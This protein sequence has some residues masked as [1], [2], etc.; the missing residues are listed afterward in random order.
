MSKRQ[1]NEEEQEQLQNQRNKRKVKQ[2]AHKHK[3]TFWTSLFG[4]KK[5][6]RLKSNSQGFSR[7]EDL[8][9]SGIP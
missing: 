3:E 5:T 9:D 6:D 8:D 1:E 7:A 4:K 2:R